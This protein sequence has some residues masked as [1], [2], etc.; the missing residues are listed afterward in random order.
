[1]KR[2]SA[3]IMSIVFSLAMVATA[4]TASFTDIDH[5]PHRDAIEEMARL[6]ILEGVGNNLFVPDMELNRAAAAKV[7]AF[8]LG[9]NEADAAAAAEWDARFPD[10]HEGMGQH[11]WALGWINLMGADGIIIGM[12]GGNYEPGSPLQMVQWVTILTRILEHEEEEMAWPDDYNQMAEDLGLTAGLDY[13]GA[14]IVNRAEMARMSHTAIYDVERPDGLRIIDIVEFTIVEPGDPEPPDDEFLYYNDV[15]L[16]LA[17]SNNVVPPGGGQQ[18]YITAIV[19]YGEDNLPAAGTQVE[20]FAHGNDQDKRQQLSVKA[21]VTDANGVATT[22]YTTA[23]ADDEKQIYFM[24]NVPSDDDWVEQGAHAL[25][26]DVASL[27]EGRLVNPFT[28][29]PVTGAKIDLHDDRTNYYVMF[30]RVTD[31]NGAYLLPVLP[32]TYHVHFHLD[33]GVSS[34]YTG[35]FSSSHSNFFADNTGII[36]VELSV[37]QNQQ[38][39]IDSE[40]GILKG[41]LT[42][43]G[44]L[45]ELYAYRGADGYTVALQLTADGSF[46]VA[47]P[48]GTYTLGTHT[49]ATLRHTIKMEKGQVTNLGS[50]SR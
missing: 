7:A 48:E 1:M 46:M 29:E 20:F 44:S 8:L 27:L 30:D 2:L 26:S 36:R 32:G 11:E 35:T 28:G 6:G 40:M 47:L 10:V 42:N 45:N 39:I 13:E 33:F 22:T 50:F 12:P 31:K 34:Y 18:V 4:Y 21:A 49:G 5:T 41:T 38:Y 9:Y 16:S 23:A 37:G 25:V 43:K 3:L 24:A 17:L 19:T 15:S 14:A